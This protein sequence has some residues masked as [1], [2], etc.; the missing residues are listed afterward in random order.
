MGYRID[1]RVRNVLSD[2]EYI[3]MLSAAIH[4]FQGPNISNETCRMS[5]DMAQSH[6]CKYRY[7]ATEDQK[8]IDKLLGFDLSE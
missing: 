3:Y 6:Q 7:D 1:G 2:H 8:R 5:G 4:M